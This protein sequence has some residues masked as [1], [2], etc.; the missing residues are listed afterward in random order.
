M[1]VTVRRTLIRGAVAVF[2]LLAVVSDAAW[3]K[4]IYR[5]PK[6]KKF[7][8]I[9]GGEVAVE[10][11][12]CDE[13]GVLPPIGL[14]DWLAPELERK[15]PQRSRRAESSWAYPES[16]NTSPAYVQ[17][18]FYK[19]LLD[20]AAEV[21]LRKGLVEESRRF[22]CRAVQTARAMRTTFGWPKSTTACALS[23]EFGICEDGERRS[24]AET[25]VGIVRANRHRVDYGTIGSGCVLRQLFENGYA[26]DAY[27]MMVQP[28]YPGYGYL[29]N[30]SDLT[31]FPEEWSVV[32]VGQSRNHGAFA[33]VV[34]CMYRYLAGIRHVSRQPGRSHVEICPCFPKGLADFS[35]THEG[36]SVSW[37]RT[38]KTVDVEVVVPRGKNASYRFADGRCRDLAEG[39]WSLSSGIS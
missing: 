39:S 20:L 19:R 30:L 24:V 15:R 34:A 36:F 25:L 21:A 16:T 32:G 18:A 14:G 4:D 11:F 13:R 8:S 22:R 1:N 12:L 27:R 29:A 3:A 28:D 23:L 26:D 33:D 35:A 5:A 17:T 7:E 38:G 2:S 37:R 9:P 6:G 31:A 10:S